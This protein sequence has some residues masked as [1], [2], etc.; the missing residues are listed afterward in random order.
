MDADF[1]HLLRE[2]ADDVGAPGPDVETGWGRLN[3]AEALDA[4]RAEIGIWHDEV[5]GATFTSAG[6]DTLRLGEPGPGTF[7]RVLGPLR[8]ERIEVT[9]TVA[10][11]DSF[12]D[13]VRVWPRVGG[14]MT[15]RGDFSVP[16]FTPWADVERRD[17]RSF[18]LRGYIYRA[19]DST[20]VPCGEDPWLPLPPDQARFGFTV[21]GRVTR[22]SPLDVAKAPPPRRIAAPL[23]VTP[24]P[25]RASTRIA[26]PAGARITIFDTAGRIVRRGVVQGGTGVF[27]WD[28]RDAR[29]R[30]VPIGL[31]FVSAETSRARQHAR[32]VRIE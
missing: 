26:G 29:G 27:S 13:S 32:A 31:Y 8:V 7:E 19:A 28:G 17:A 18:M 4:V 11:P 9:A 1:Q 21:M 22:P 2:N 10:I 23:R 3:A 5:A 20:C 12:T 16:Y 30:S 25:F 15:T 14:T 6:F 24:N